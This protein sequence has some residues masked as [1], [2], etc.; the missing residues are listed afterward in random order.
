MSVE[1][2]EILVVGAGPAGLIAAREA[3]RRGMEVTVLEEDAEIGLPCH[4][5]G[6]LSL[7]GLETI[8]A[9]P[10]DS[11]IQNKV[12]GARF[13]SPSGLSFTVERSETV[14][15]IVDRNLFDKKLAHQ[16]TKAGA[17]IKLNEKVHSIKRVDTGIIS[18]RERESL[19]AKILI[20]AEGTSSRILRNIGLKT[21]NFNYTLPG[22]QFDLNGTNL[23]P[24]YVEIYV[25]RRIAPNF[26]AWVIPLGEKMARVG[27][28]CK[29]A[30]PKER[31]DR[32]I[33]DRFG[34]D[35]NELERVATRSGLIVTCG[36]IEKTFDDNLLVVGD[37]A[38]QVK[39]TTGGGVI[40]SGMCASIAGEVAAEAVIKDNFTSAFLRRYE[41]SWKKRFGKEFRMT[42]LA[43]RIMDH[44]S[45]KTIDKLFKII[46]EENL[47]EEMSAEGDMDFQRGIFMKLIKRKEILG[48]LRPFWRAL[49]PFERRT[50]E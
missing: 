30:K 4:C 35:N 22:L 10:P 46:I 1:K 40:L 34:S 9:P 12:R 2:A 20:D 29:G 21:L 6:L 7:K 8:G 39:P 43:R 5:A 23:D 48:I 47:Q 16:A 3:A 36:P 38:G 42:R 24:D 27:L 49:S 32:F 31:L 18:A 25:G 45:D 11:F 17:Q 28:A 19:E 26:F 37:A 44:L 13:F 41:S 15:Y 14:A 33:K 50:E